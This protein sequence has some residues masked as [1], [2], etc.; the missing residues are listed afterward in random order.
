MFEIIFHSFLVTGNLP[1]KIPKID[2]DFQFINVQM[3]LFRFM[4]QN[5]MVVYVFVFM[6][7][8]LQQP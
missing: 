3:E 8:Y 2:S 5:E 4:V 7:V 1:K 6:L